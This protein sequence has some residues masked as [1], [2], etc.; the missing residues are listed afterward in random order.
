MLLPACTALLLPH[1][2]AEGARAHCAPQV[3]PEHQGR[4][5][6]WGVVGAALMRGVCI[7]MGAAVLQRFRP[8]LLCCA[9]FLLFSAYK[10]FFLQARPPPAVGPAAAA[11]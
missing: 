7:A 11:A 10:M 6:Q 8:V 5:L 1:A 9:V 2:E 4:V 3:P